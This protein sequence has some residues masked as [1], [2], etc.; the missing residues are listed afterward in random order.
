MPNG[1]GDKNCKK[2]KSNKQQKKPVDRVI[3]HCYACGADGRA[4]GRTV[5]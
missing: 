5:T 2:I 4:D 1:D 3:L